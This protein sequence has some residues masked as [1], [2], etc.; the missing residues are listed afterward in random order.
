[1]RTIKAVASPRAERG[2]YAR[3]QDELECFALALSQ[4]WATLGD[5]FC[6]SAKARFDLGG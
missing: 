5:Q 4:I 3:A 2:Q 1:M 6:E